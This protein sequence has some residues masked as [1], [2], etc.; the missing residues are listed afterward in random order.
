MGKRTLER[1]I[2]TFWSRVAITANDDKCWEWQAGKIYGGYGIKAWPGG[3]QLAHRV[4]WIVNNGEI[5]DGLW[6]LH[7]CDNPSC[8]NPKH[9]FLG[10]PKDNTNDMKAKGR[11]SHRPPKGDKHPNHKITDRQVNDIIKRYQSNE[12]TQAQLAKEYNVSKSCMTNIVNGKTRKHA[13]L[14]AD[15]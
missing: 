14:L 3:E 6:V 15:I 2:I 5:P 1:Q 7:S 9:L 13:K 12:A 11:G 10:T 4:S 8:V